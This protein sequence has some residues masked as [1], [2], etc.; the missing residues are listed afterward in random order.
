MIHCQY[1]FEPFATSLGTLAQM[2]RWKRLGD[3]L[4]GPGTSIQFSEILYFAFGMAAIGV[5]VWLVVRW[6]QR[7]DMSQRCDDP[8]KLFRELC[9]HHN[10][11]RTD[12]R[13]LRKLVV[14]REMHQPAELFV[15][16]SAFDPV[17]LP[18]EI[19]QQQLRNLKARLF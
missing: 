19:N 13:M 16:P 14:A 3:G 2:S 1:N 17:D 9:Q 10:L 15:T 18:S 11:N 4:R 7:N 8:W 5:I 12:S 6:R